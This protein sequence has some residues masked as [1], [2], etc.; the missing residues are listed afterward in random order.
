MSELDRTLSPLTEAADDD[1]RRL[2]GL[3]IAALSRVRQDGDHWI[4]P[5][6]TG[7]GRYSVYPDQDRCTC[8]D[9]E[10]RQVR[11]KHLFAVEF[12]IKREQHP[13]GSATVTQ[14]VRVTYRQEWSVYNRAQTHEHERFLPLLRE[15][16]DGIEQPAQT[17]GR[18]RLPLSDV[19]FAL[20]VRTYSGLSA[21]R[22]DSLVRDAATR[23]LLDAAPSY[24]SGLR[25]LESAEL[26]E[27]LK[28]LI[29]ESVRIAKVLIIFF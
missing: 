11:C 1:P 3:E 5:S 7:T 4:V 8:P 15:L 16:C 26:T 23:G 21:R 28:A 29:E 13:D 6:Q 24:N 14:A 17:M 25:Y 22:G 27:V 12:T 2:R 19:V 9:H 18:P 10:T 20:G